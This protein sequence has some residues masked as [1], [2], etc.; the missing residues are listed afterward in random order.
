MQDPKRSDLPR[1]FARLSGS[2]PLKIVRALYHL[3]SWARLVYRLLKDPRMPWWLKTLPFLA[4]AYV[5]CPID[6]IPDFIPALGVTDD[7]GVVFLAIS[8]FFR[9]APPAVLEEH[10]RAISG[11]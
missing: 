10:V 5:L 3:P 6:V 8:I 11:E 4:I 9:K 1:D 2:G 7:V